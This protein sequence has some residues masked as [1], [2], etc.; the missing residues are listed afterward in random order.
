MR[1]GCRW[2]GVNGGGHTGGGEVDIAGQRNLGAAEI[3]DK[4]A[5]KFPY[6]G[7]LF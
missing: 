1:D 5:S 3:A 2:R 4:S 6:M 7:C